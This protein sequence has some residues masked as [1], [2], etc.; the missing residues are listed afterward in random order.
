[1]TVSIPK[2]HPG[3]LNFRHMDLSYRFQGSQVWG[4][5]TFKTPHSHRLKCASR[6]ALNFRHVRPINLALG[7]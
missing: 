2:A 5:N 6:A 7:T 1:M 3:P 4:S